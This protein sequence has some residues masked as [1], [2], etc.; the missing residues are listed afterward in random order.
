[1]VDRGLEKDRRRC[2]RIIMGEGE[3]ELEGQILVRRVA[4][5]VDGRSPRQEVTV[6]VGES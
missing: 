4:R 2:I 5:P 6:C 3:G 1:M